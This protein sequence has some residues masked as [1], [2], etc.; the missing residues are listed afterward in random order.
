M[1]RTALAHHVPDPAAAW[2]VQGQ[3]MLLDAMRATGQLELQENI[4]QLLWDLDAANKDCTFEREDVRALLTVLEG[5]ASATVASHI[6]HFLH[7]CLV[8]KGGRPALQLGDLAGW[9]G[10]LVKEVAAHKHHLQVGGGGW[11]GLQGGSADPR[12]PA[13][14]VCLRVAVFFG[15]IG[16][17]TQHCWGLGTAHGCWSGCWLATAG[18]G[19]H[20]LLKCR[21]CPAMPCCA[22][23]AGCGSVHAGHAAG[24]RAGRCHGAGNGQ[25]ATAERAA[26]GAV[27]GP[28]HRAVPM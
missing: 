14:R 10:R 19:T 17:S 22:V 15:L 18:A 5:T 23:P 6:L 21:C 1:W 20:Y 9:A 7:S 27:Q 16:R 11:A 8:H 24:R 26:A 12:R 2:W 28:G 3:T 25:G 4:V 13:G